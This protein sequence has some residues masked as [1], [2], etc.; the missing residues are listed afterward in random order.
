M[1]VVLTLCL[2]GSDLGEDGKKKGENRLENGKKGCLVGLNCFI[3]KSIKISSLQL[4]RKWEE[5]F[6]STC[7]HPSIVRCCCFI[8]LFFHSKLLKDFFSI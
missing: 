5:E 7:F 2:V 6:L 8:F 1:L 4:G 3:S